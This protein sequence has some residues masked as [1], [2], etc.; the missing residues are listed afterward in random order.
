MYRIW[1]V[2]DEFPGF[3]LS[4][5]QN[6]VPVAAMKTDVPMS[7]WGEKINTRRSGSGNRLAQKDSTSD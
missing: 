1:H 2:F 4:P 7:A 3:F 5:V 6:S